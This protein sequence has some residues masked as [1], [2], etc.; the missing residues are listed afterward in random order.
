L[1]ESFGPASTYFVFAGIGVVA[2]VTINNIVPETKG[3]SLEEIEKLWGPLDG[4]AGVVAEVS[5]E[6][7]TH[8]E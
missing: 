5:A 1:T 2:L 6:E 8:R 4:G 7:A 3:R